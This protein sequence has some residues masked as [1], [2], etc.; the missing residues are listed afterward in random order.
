MALKRKIKMLVDILMYLTYAYISM[1]F[2]DIEICNLYDC[3]NNGTCTNN[4][5]QPTCNCTLGYTGEY[6]ESCEKMRCFLV[7]TC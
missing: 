6:C 4:N 5:G 7:L 2:H 1:F 3:K